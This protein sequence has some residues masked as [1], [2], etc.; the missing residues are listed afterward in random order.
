MVEA[1]SMVLGKAGFEEKE[2]V[3]AHGSIE[4]R[5]VVFRAGKGCRRCKGKGNDRVADTW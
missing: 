5:L 4:K 1:L 3:M 2:G